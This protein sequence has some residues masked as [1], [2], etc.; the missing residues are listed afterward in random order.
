MTHQDQITKLEAEVIDALEA[1]FRTD[2]PELIAYRTDI[3]L[4]KYY[5]L[6]TLKKKQ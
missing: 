2:I 5:E 1:T 3:Y 4:E 6:E